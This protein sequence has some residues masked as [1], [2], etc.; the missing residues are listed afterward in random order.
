MLPFP[1][2]QNKIL[3]HTCPSCEEYWAAQ[4]SPMSPSPGIALSQR[5]YL[6]QGHAPFLG[7]PTYS[8]SPVWGYR[9]HS[10]PQWRT[11]LKAIPA[12]EP[13]VALAEVSVGD[14]L[15]PSFSLHPTWLS[16]A[17]PA[18]PLVSILRAPLS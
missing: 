10:S 16:P 9:A 18:T 15:Q 3:Q 7:Q 5:S 1:A 14:A 8:D 12:A 17:T 11:F 2:K 4:S 13:L 6:A